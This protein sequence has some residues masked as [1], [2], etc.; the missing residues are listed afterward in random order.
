MIEKIFYILANDKTLPKEVQMELDDWYKSTPHNN[1]YAEILE[2]VSEKD[3]DDYAMPLLNKYLMEQGL[4]E[5]ETFI[6][7]S[8]W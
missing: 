5:G 8:T 4:K 6:L 1:G 2:I 7:H 3:S